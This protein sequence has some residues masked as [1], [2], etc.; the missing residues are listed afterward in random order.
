MSITIGNRWAEKVPLKLGQYP[1]HTPVVD[2]EEA[3]NTVGMRPDYILVK[4]NSL[5]EFI[6]A[7]MVVDSFAARGGKVKN[8]ILPYI[9]GGR[10]DR[11]KW[12]GDWL[13]TLRFV[14]KMINERSFDK[15]ITLDPH[16]I[17]TEAQI[18]RLHVADD[19]MV[20]MYRYA[21]GFGIDAVIAPDL[22]AAKRA[23]R[24]ANIIGVPVF[25]ATKKRDPA[26]NK[27][28]GFHF[29]DT[30]IPDQHYLIVDDICDAG[31]TFL[32]LAEEANKVYDVELSLLVTHGLFTKGDELLNKVFKHVITTDSIDYNDNRK[33]SHIVAVAEGLDTYV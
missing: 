5:D 20:H 32:G 33:N 12:E 29:V 6:T 30:L 22:G 3:W 1:D 7:M 8:L 17:A 25:T 26:T 21:K 24:V 18:D 10:Q 31:G 14:A 2:L 28:S 27:L 16:S 13:L 9:P 15:V 19:E 11:Q 23:E 4:P